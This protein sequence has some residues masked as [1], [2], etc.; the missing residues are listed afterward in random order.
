MM[1]FRGGAHGLMLYWRHVVKLGC[2]VVAVVAGACMR[3]LRGGGD[4]CM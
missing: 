4:I 3:A 1:V 2:R